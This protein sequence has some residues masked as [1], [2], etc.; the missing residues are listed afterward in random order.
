[1]K[2]D[3]SKVNMTKLQF[4]RDVFEEVDKHQQHELQLATCGLSNEYELADVVAHLAIPTEDWFDMS[5][6]QRKDYIL[7]FNRM[8]VEDAIAGKTIAVSTVSVADPTEPTG[9]FC[10]CEGISTVI[11]RLHSWSRGYNC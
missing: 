3:K 9:I 2:N 10:R 4:T 7:K 11:H 5:E 1:M 6:Y 8:T